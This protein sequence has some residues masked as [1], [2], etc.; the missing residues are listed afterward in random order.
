MV[1][2]YW[3][4]WSR[5]HETMP[6]QVGQKAS[7]SWLMMRRAFVIPCLLISLLPCLGCGG[8][9]TDAEPGSAAMKIELKSTA[10]HEGETIPKQNTADGK[11]VSPALAWSEPATGTKSF[12]LIC[13]DPD[14]PRG[15]WVHWV[16]FNLPPN[17]RSLDEG[18]AARENLENGAVHGKNDFGK[19]GYGGPSPPPGK[20][21]RYFF[22]L[23]ALD[24]GLICR[25][26]QPRIR[27]LL[28]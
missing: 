24:A 10:F 26:V 27:S 11:D 6:G 22:K 20:P 25:R 15:T 13:D 16:L 5:M 8:D 3:E 12:V 18:V 17:T 4:R 7:K 19:V 23:Y 21:H 9:R 1:H 2:A 14:A 28:P